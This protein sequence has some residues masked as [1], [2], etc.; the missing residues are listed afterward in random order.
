MF[1]I[2]SKILSQKKKKRAKQTNKGT[3]IGRSKRPGG[4]KNKKQNNK[5]LEGPNYS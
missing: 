5:T 3:K 1:R 2:Y 4:R